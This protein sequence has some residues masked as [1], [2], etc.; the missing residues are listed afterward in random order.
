MKRLGLL[1]VGI[2][3]AALSACTSTK[4]TSSW[5]ADDAQLKKGDKV[6]VM[7]LLPEKERPLRVAM[8][9]SMVEA[10]KK[11]G[12]VAVSSLQAY[13]P[14]AFRKTDENGVVSKLRGG[15]A[16]K[17]LTIVL[18][19][20]AREKTYVRGTGYG[21]YPF[22]YGRF[23]PYYS[24]WYGRMYDPGYYRTDTKYYWESNLYDLN[25]RKLLYSAQTQSVDPPTAMR[26]AYLYSQQVVKDLKKQ[27]LISQ[28][29]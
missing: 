1:V 24:M 8:E 5:K 4:L 21:P 26:Q 20:K 17:V 28:A 3:L 22:Y 16:S 9:N 18:L 14:E 6:V 10:M 11:Q 2:A 12:Y 27:Q 29:S 15:D 13:G 23:W 19:D 7:A 25:D